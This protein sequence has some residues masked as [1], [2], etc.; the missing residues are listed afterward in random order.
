[1]SAPPGQTLLELLDLVPTG[2]DRWS[3]PTPAEGRPTLFGGQ[4]A[5]QAL[6]AASFTVPSDR[7]PHSLHAYFIRP[8]RP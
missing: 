6:R 8:G 2:A 4:V 7:P 1:M 5:A 3:A